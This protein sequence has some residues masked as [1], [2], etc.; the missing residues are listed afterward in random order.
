M[1][2]VPGF[3]FCR[4]DVLRDVERTPGMCFIWREIR[5]PHRRAKRARR[6]ST[7][8]HNMKNS[9]VKI[10]A[11]TRA[12]AAA[13][14]VA[15]TWEAANSFRR[16]RAVLAKVTASSPPNPE[17]TLHWAIRVPLVCAG[18][19]AG[20]DAVTGFRLSNAVAAKIRGPKPEAESQG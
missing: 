2:H 13:G 1:P 6:S 18:V 14:A 17:E 7:K 8:K 4:K 11:L 12:V 10:G 15:F 19:A 5:T 9:S 20:V 16:S 3:V